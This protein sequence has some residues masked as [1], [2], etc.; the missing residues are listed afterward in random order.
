MP[1]PNMSV[2]IVAYN[3][4]NFIDKC[5][6][7]VI[8]NLQSGGEIIVIDNSSTDGTVSELEKFG[9]KIKLI[10][11]TEN[12][13]FAKACNK[14]A[15]EASGDYLFILNPDTQLDKPI[16]DDLVSFYEDIPEVGIV[17]PKLIMADG[18]VQQSVKK[19]P[20]IWGAFKEYILGVKNAYSQY[21]PAGDQPTEVEMVYGAAMLIKR[22]LFEKLGGFNEQ[23]FLYYED[24]DLCKRVR[25]VG[26]RIYYYPKV[27]LIH[28]VGATKSGSKYEKNLESSK[29]YHGIFKFLILQLIFRLHRF[30]P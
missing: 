1:V 14:A 23:F 2:V 3:S 30:I 5:I 6:S 19:L 12:L 9:S 20:T 11:S 22:D 21:I 4:E 8:K 25:E 28:L 26:K 29:R 7:S 17:A 18:K 10:K 16:L 15:K 27:S 13:G 24:A